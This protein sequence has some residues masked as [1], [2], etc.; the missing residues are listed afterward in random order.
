[1]KK[2]EYKQSMIAY[3]K[4]YYEMSRLCQRMLRDM[5]RQIWI[6]SLLCGLWLVSGILWG[7]SLARW[8]TG[9]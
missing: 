3:K 2:E 9:R 7:L 4:G 8:L 6:T 5:R 1:M